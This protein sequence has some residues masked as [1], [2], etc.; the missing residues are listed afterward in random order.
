MHSLNGYAFSE[1]PDLSAD[2]SPSNSVEIASKMLPPLGHLGE[3]MTIPFITLVVARTI[4][5]YCG[6][7]DLLLSLTANQNGTAQVLRLTWND[8]Q[9]WE[10]CIAGVKDVISDAPKQ[11]IRLS[12]SELR[13][14]LSLSA[15]Q[16]PCLALCQFGQPNSASNSEYPV[17]FSYDVSSG[18]L[19]LSASMAVL[20]PTVATQI[21]EQIHGLVTRALDQPLSKITPIALLP[22]KLMSISERGTDETMVEA[23]SHLAPVSFAPDYLTLRAKD[24]PGTTAVRW[25]P[26]LSLDSPKQHFE[27]I[28]YIELEKKAN[29]IA[30][31]LLRNGLQREDRVGVCMERNLSFHAAMMGIMRAG[32]CYVPIDPELP[33]ERKVYIAKDANA[34]FVLTSSQI[35]TLD[36]FGSMTRYIEDELVQLEISRESDSAVDFM[37]PDGLAYL[38]YTSG[39]TGNPKGCLLTHRGLSQAILALSSTAADVRMDN[40]HDGRYLAVASIAF[41]V[42][43]A[44]TIVP[45]ALGMPLISA[46]RSQL[47]EN[48]PIYVNKLGVTHLGIVP[49]LIEATLN[50]AQGEDGDEIALRYIASG[51]EKMSDSI[52]DKW[53][54]HPQ[55]RLAN[56]YGP[57]EVTIGCCARFMT[58]ATPRANIGRAL[59]SVSAYVVDADMNI[60]LRGSVGELV[61]E[62]PLVGRGY[63]G[64][65]DLTEKVFVEWPRTGCWSYRTGDLVRMMPDSTLEILGRIDTQIKL[66][67]V[68]I[69]SEGISAIIRSAVPQCES[70]SLDVTTILAKHPVINVEQLVSVFSWDKSVSIST[71]KSKKPEIVTPPFGMI[72]SIKAKCENELPGYMRP[73]HFIPL[74]WLPL[75]SNGKA[76]AKL[77]TQLFCGLDIEVLAKVAVG[78]DSKDSRPCT[79]IENRI[80]EV[81]QKHV[82]LPFDKPHPE[83]NVFECGLDSMAVIRFSTELKDIF[84]AKISASAIMKGPRIS[85]IASY[86]QSLQATYLSRAVSFTSSVSDLNADPT[87]PYN[88]SQIEAILPPFTV[89]EGVLARSSDSDSLYV[90]HVVLSLNAHISM[91]QVR[92][93]WSSVVSRHPILRTIFNFG[94]ALSQI[95]LKPNV[96]EL[97]WKDHALS[98]PL[99]DSSFGDYFLQGEGSNVAKEINRTL[100]SVPPYRLSAYTSPTQKFLVLSIHHALFDGISLPLI[101]REVEQKHLGQNCAPPSSSLDILAHISS[102]D[103]NDAKNFW[104]E[105]FSG[106]SWTQ[107]ALIPS[108]PHTTQRHVV[109]FQS[110]LSSLKVLSASQQATLQA[111]LTSSF[112]L[113]LARDVYKCR[114][115]TFGVLR[116]GRLLPI[117]NIDEAICPLVSVVPTRVN[118]DNLETSLQTIQQG[119]S[120]IVE[121][122]HL[123]LGKVQTWVRPGRPLFDILFSLSVDK[124]SSNDLWNVI[125]SEPPKADYPLAVEVVLNLENDSLL[126]QAAWI[127]NPQD[128]AILTCLRELE[129]TVH[130]LA[131]NPA[132]YIMQSLADIPRVVYRRKVEPHKETLVKSEIAH[133]N[134]ELLDKLRYIIADF[135]QVQ[136]TI[137]A[138]STSFI[139]MGLDSIKSVGLSKVITMCGHPVSSTNVLRNASLQ[140]L[141]SYILSQSCNSDAE[142]DFDAA[143]KSVVIVDKSITAEI[144]SHN[145]KFED[146]D[147]VVLFPTTALQSGM[148]SQTVSSRGKLYLHSFPLRMSG[149][150]DVAQLHAAWSTAVRNFSVLRTSFHFSTECGVWVQAIHSHATLDWAEKVVKSID[151]YNEALQSFLGTINLDDEAG[152]KHPPFWVRLFNHGTT[153]STV[154]FAMHHALYDGVSIGLLVNAVEEFYHSRSCHYDKQFHEVLPDILL[155]QRDGVDFW[156]KKVARFTPK[157]FQ[158]VRSL[159]NSTSVTLERSIPLDASRVKAALSEA[160]VTMQCV[161]QAAWAKVMGKYTGVPD[162]VFGHTVSGRSIPGAEDVIGPVLNTIPCCVRLERDIQTIQF[163]RN[164]H[165][166]NLDALPYQ[167]AATRAIQKALKVD[168]LWDTLF[169]FQSVENQPRAEDCAKIW[170]FDENSGDKDAKIQ[171]PLNIE[172]LHCDTGIIVKC[173]SDPDFVGPG[174][175]DMMLT[176]L[177]KFFVDIFDRLHDRAFSDLDIFVNDSRLDATVKAQEIPQMQAL[178]SLPSTF[179]SDIDPSIYEPILTSLTNAPRSLI[180][181]ET[182]LVTIGIDSISAIQ[183]SGRFRRAGMILSASD[184]VSSATIGQ[185]VTKIRLMDTFVPKSRSDSSVISEVSDA[186]KAAIMRHLNLQSSNIERISFAS[187]GMQWLIG[188]WSKSSRTRYQHAFPFELAQDIDRDMMKASWFGLV[189]RH[190]ILRSTFICADGYHESRIVI[191]NKSAPETWS[192]EYVPVENFYSSVLERMK[193]LVRNPIPTSQPQARA[194]FFYSDSH[195]YLILHLHHFQYD[196]WSLRLL[197]DD[198]TCLYSGTKSTVSNDMDLFLGYCSS[199]NQQQLEEQRSYWRKSFPLEFK[200]TFFPVL[201]SN[202]RSHR[203]NER[204]VRTNTS[205][206]HNASRL[207]ERARSLGVSLPSVFL[208]SWAHIQGQVTKASS[209]TFGLWHSG[210]TSALD[211]IEN[212][213]IPCMNVLPMHVSS[214]RQK[215]ALELAA[216]I[217]I[218]LRKRTSVIEQSNQVRVNE[219]VGTSKEPMCNVF[220]NIIKIG[221]D[222]SSNNL[223]LRP[224]NAPYFVPA[225][226][227]GSDNFTSVCLD[228]AHVIRDDLFIDFATLDKTDTVMMSIDSAAYLM[229]EDH[230]DDLMLRWSEGVRRILGVV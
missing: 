111:L 187:S 32:G 204:L 117:D 51:G 183:I 220:I 166:A 1:W 151:E 72:K 30:H 136:P 100:S 174:D 24:M 161:S 43:L 145:I 158:R 214:I 146:D 228:I 179:I 118:F 39:T 200:P 199:F 147:V 127:N 92:N 46:R 40:I 162:I 58:S 98:S 20:H 53:A 9:T 170:T 197:I 181:P 143:R 130:G 2:R 225:E 156:V 195:A 132:F 93:A 8:D 167:Q 226:T 163:L 50:A 154:V 178:G 112:A 165:Q 38:L 10:E 175:L 160:S 18:T 139:S 205:C 22:S 122:E 11:P 221:P 23:Y 91:P 208:A 61:V 109:Q 68:R 229:D 207:D 198:L 201:K 108:S 80:F 129:A 215:S 6:T 186:E 223:F 96:G 134:P 177:E 77:L 13:D 25:Y 83:L 7:N 114:D 74:S 70:L 224:A 212:L 33:L 69:E 73:A 27:S 56:F 176:D 94:R 140:Q 47:L 116:S 44:E 188:M 123:P 202:A 97:N 203:P 219:W 153:G 63:Q 82:T 15:S 185:M 54:N 184:V 149:S 78:E 230:A 155:Q 84:K 144:F 103:H 125:E 41:D 89:Q 101:F 133:A 192:E 86:L 62:G 57:S 164:I 110:S 49:S 169:L 55:V 196:A 113:L 19:E 135:L 159:Q 218:D 209:S 126:V 138:P 141:V 105:Y 34:A 206:I 182:N 12:T 26:E 42:H 48:L 171:Y 28:S 79:D 16:Y 65:P 76:D 119:I 107:P 3:N 137:L 21:V 60:L 31:W 90:Q 5:A 106:F 210:R 157:R 45:F 168:A 120:S 227:I 172:I 52:L 71:R 173:A 115:V 95:V 148:L 64:R 124:S 35:T 150:F 85:E 29:Q 99:A 216:D 131:T 81:L 194:L 190:P 88:P 213:A 193:S 67:G 14:T 104:V 142:K 102:I 87:L 189:D 191:F 66:R 17:V 59:A 75:S 217:L 222:V 128:E 37:K 4:G 211:D 36:V 152:F 180:R 121:F